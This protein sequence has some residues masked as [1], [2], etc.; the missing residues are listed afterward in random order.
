MFSLLRSIGYTTIDSRAQ[1]TFKESPATGRKAMT[2]S[3]FTVHAPGIDAAA[4]VEEIRESV[5]QKTAEGLYNDALIG[6]AECSNLIN[7]QNDEEFFQYY[8]TCMQR[9]ATVDIRAFQIPDPK[10]GPIGKAMV[11]LKKTI[12][13]L[14]KFYTYRMWSQQ[15]QVNSLA[16]NGISITN[17]R[18]SGKIK[19]Q[20]LRIAALEEALKQ[21]NIS[22]PEHPKDDA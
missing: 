6:K 22:I 12:W 18:F 9:A 2:E 5:A 16:M 15:N 8:I 19:E 14:L 17:A 10:G 20:E 11:T 21:A 4:L 1:L 3:N 13:S 7:M